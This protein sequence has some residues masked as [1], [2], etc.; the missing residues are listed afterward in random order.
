MSPSASARARFASLAPPRWRRP[1]LV[2]LL[3]VLGLGYWSC[4]TTHEPD[5]A[6]RTGTPEPGPD[7]VASAEGAAG[8]PEAGDE[9]PLLPVLNEEA[10]TARVA[11]QRRL[12][13]SN[14]F[15]DVRGRPVPWITPQD[16]LPDDEGP[17]PDEDRSIDDALLDSLPG[18]SGLGGPGGAEVTAGQRINGNALG[19][20]V[21]IEGSR[22]QGPP[23]QRFYDALEALRR[24]EDADG[25]VRVLVYGGSHTD[26][27]VYPQYIRTYL[28]ERF[29]DG[30][31]G[32]VHVAKPWRWYRH[33]DY[34]VEGSKH[35]TTEHAQ[36]RKGRMDGLYGY[37]GT[38]LSA[39]SKRAVGKIHPRGDAVGAVYE[40][41]FLRQPKGGSFK[42]LADGELQATVKTRADALGPGYHRFVLP[43]GQH[44]IEIELSGNGEVRMFGMTIEREQ[45]GVVV[46]T[47]GIGGTRAA[48]MLQWNED[49][50]A[51]NVAHRDPDLVTFFYGTNEATD[52][53]QPIEA[54]ENDLRAVLDRLATVA[55]QASCLLMGPGDFP[56]RR[57]DGTWGNRARIDQIIDVQRRVAADHGCGFWD[58]KAFMGGDLSMP[59]WAAA[60][61]PMAKQDH[62][63]FTK[64]GYV[65]IGMAVMDA[66]MVAFDGADLSG[67]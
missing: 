28:Q 14:L 59:L 2:G 57:E 34:W 58:T 41:Y 47:L 13:G 65:R 23:L 50:W 3:G 63:H 42:V 29:G 43:E 37:M 31:H 8:V 27:D 64:R 9:P 15:E 62:I 11:A 52:E 12:L 24:G 32:F 56:R 10:L 22:E 48:N 21:P 49:I 53:D 30:G 51:D 18:S 35:W 20:F 6:E 60:Q 17:T 38:S 1:L 36:R 54:Y 67:G 55:P 25:K 5:P 16:E 19:L 4:A 61:P 46:D 45:P 7:G 66:M 40:L 39:K 33:A 44:H 26:A